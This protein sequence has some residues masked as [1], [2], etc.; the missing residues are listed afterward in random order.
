MVQLLFLQGIAPKAGRA[1]RTAV[2][3]M[4]MRQKPGRLQDGTA[5]TW[6]SDPFY[7]YLTDQYFVL[8]K[9]DL[10]N[11]QSGEEN[12]FIS[13]FYSGAVYWIGLR[14]NETNS[15]SFV[16]TDG[17]AM[18]YSNWQSGEPNN[19]GTEEEE[20]VVTGYLGP[21]FWNDGRCGDTIYN[22]GFVCEKAESGEEETNPGN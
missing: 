18:T 1:S 13:N 10:V 5:L 8:L 2:I 14:R 19:W 12:D 9:A 22:K 16:W 21:S 20:C 11:I 6:R 3:F 4:K 17:T 7:Q 15:D